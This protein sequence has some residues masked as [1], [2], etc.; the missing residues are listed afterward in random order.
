MNL[1]CMILV[2]SLEFQKRIL[3]VDP[4]CAIDGCAKSCNDEENIHFLRLLVNHRMICNLVDSFQNLPSISTC[5]IFPAKRKINHSSDNRLQR[6][7]RC[8]EIN[9]LKPRKRIQITRYQ[10]QRES[11]KN[12]PNPSNDASQ[13]SSRQTTKEHA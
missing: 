9:I 1:W 4:K 13:S 5:S 8:I 10:H 2:S 3:H 6:L 7:E 12:K 11:R